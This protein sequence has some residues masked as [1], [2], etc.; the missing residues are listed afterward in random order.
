MCKKTPHSLKVLGDMIKNMLKKYK[1]L[2]IVNNPTDT[3]RFGVSILFI[4]H[5]T[6]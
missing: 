4:M 5:P 1:K 3:N 6:P 2:P